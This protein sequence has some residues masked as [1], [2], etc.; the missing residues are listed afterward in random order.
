MPEGIS[1]AALRS[2]RGGMLVQGHRQDARVLV[3]RGAAEETTPPGTGKSTLPI[4]CQIAGIT[5]R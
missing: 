3:E 4:A 5:Y 2:K 1:I